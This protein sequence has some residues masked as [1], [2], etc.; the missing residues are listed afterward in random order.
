MIY[1]YNIAIRRDEKKI[2]ENDTFFSEYELTQ[3]DC[4]SMCSNYKTDVIIACVGQF[5]PFSKAEQRKRSFYSEYKEE[6]PENA[7]V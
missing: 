4:D 1:V 5:K 7:E 6:E 2:V 3:Q